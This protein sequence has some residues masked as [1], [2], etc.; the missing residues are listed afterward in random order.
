MR[1]RAGLTQR[2]L[3]ELLGHSQ[4]FVTAAERGALRLDGLQIRDWAAACGTTLTAWARGVER[5][6]A[7]R[8]LGG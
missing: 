7:A 1:A 3:S 6:L 2:E 8:S 5:R 4:N